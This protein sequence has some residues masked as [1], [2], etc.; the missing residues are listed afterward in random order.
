V[1]ADHPIARNELGLVYRKLGRFADARTSYESALALYP[2]FHVA[3]KN[4]AILCDLYQRDYSC[5]L[6]HYQAYRAVVADDPQVPIW[7]SDLEGRAS[8]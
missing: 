7:I 2:D 4:L 8:P 3:N 1:S 6:R 5:A